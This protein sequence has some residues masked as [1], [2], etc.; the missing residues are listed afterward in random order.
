MAVGGGTV[1]AGGAEPVTVAAV[2]GRVENRGKRECSL[3]VGEERE[4][5]D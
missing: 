4:R 1:A 3:W 5:S 2:L